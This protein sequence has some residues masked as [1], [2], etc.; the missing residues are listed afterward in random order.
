MNFRDLKIVQLEWWLPSPSCL[1]INSSYKCFFFV[2]YIHSFPSISY[3]SHTYSSPCHLISS[4]LSWLLS[5]LFPESKC[6][7]STHTI[8][9]LHYPPHQINFHKTIFYPLLLLKNTLWI[10]SAKPF[11]LSFKE[12]HTWPQS[13]L[14]NSTHLSSTLFFIWGHNGLITICLRGYL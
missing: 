8:I 12:V 9:H 11:G 3:Y 14:P 5:D 6:F 10:F 4:W 7:A 1:T 13:S 2:L